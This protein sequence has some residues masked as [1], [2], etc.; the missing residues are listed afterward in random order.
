MTPAFIAIDWGTT[1]LRAV[2]ADRKGRALVRRA[3][4][5]GILAVP[6]GDFDGALERLVGDWDK[7]LAVAASGM[8]TSKQGWI[9]VP[10][11]D[12]PAGPAEL[13]AAA[14]KHVSAA[15]RNMLFIG[16]VRCRTAAGV[17]DVMRGEETQ[18][19]GCADGAAIYVAPGT[20]SKWIAMADGR[21]GAFAT[22][23]TGEVY[24]LLRNH[25][26]LARL[27]TV[28]VENDEAFTAGVRSA[29]ADPAGLLHRMFAARTLALFDEMPAANLASFLSGQVIGTEVAHAANSTGKA[30]RHIVLA[31]EALVGKY[32]RAMELAGLR[33]E[34]GPTDAAV[35]GQ[36]RIMETIGLLR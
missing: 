34:A 33:A 9:E 4:P 21:I 26:I 31:S 28:E 35:L 14:R 19:M 32:I 10:Y 25:S 5:E 27:M 6:G 12:C 7:G 1:S 16:G 20:H 18:V 3:A 22:Y 23:M 15:G 2:L 36:A 8:I 11:A 30:A 29:L 17:P 13:A 24:A